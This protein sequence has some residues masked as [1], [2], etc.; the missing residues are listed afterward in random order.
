MWY[1]AVFVIFFICTVCNESL[2]LAVIK[3]NVALINPLSDT[4]VDLNKP[5]IIG[6]GGE[7]SD[8]EYLPTKTE[9]AKYLQNTGTHISCLFGLFKQHHSRFNPAQDHKKQ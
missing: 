8:L 9:K 7:L 2:A 1:K 5:R 6:N 4:I 3:F